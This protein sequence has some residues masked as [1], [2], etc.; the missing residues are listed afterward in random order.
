MKIRRPWSAVRRHFQRRKFTMSSFTRDD[1]ILPATRWIARIIVPILGLAFIILYGLPHRTTEYFAWTIKPT[2]TPMM[3]GA[4][5]LAGAY[6]FARVALASRW[7]HVALG[8]PA[9]SAFVWF[10]G[11]ATILHYDRF[12]HSHPAFIAWLIL[13]AVTP[14]LIP[15][16]WWFNRQTDPGVSDT[17]DAV[18]PP[19]ARQVMALIGIINL[20]NA[21]LMLLWPALFIPIWPW[22]LTPLTTRVVAGWFALPGVVALGVAADSRWSA[23]R[24]T[25]QSQMFGIGLILLAVVRAWHEFDTAKVTT[26]V[27]VGGLTLL[28]LAV[29]WLYVYMERPQ[30]KPAPMQG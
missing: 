13:Y 28:L 25:L 8:L 29:G 20:G 10:M 6:F 24:M 14:F 1:H 15:A 27:F 17:P 9:V 4:G 30:T 12:N 11:M 16:L 21:F 22:Q 26:W 5:Y 3:M 2:M 19:L 23:A 18:I 7:H